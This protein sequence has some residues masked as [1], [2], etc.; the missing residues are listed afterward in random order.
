MSRNE[1]GFTLPETIIALAVMGL[2]LPVIF[3]IFYLVLSV[4]I[5]GGSS[6][7]ASLEAAQSVEVISR[8]GRSAIS[9]STPVPA[10]PLDYGTFYWLDY[11]VL[12]PIT[13]TVRYYYDPSNLSLARQET[14]GDSVTTRFIA[15]N[16]RNFGDVA[17]FPVGDS[18]SISVTSSI[19]S[20]VSATGVVTRGVVSQAQSRPEV[21]PSGFTFGPNQDSYVDQNKPTLN[22]GGD[23]DFR[24][25]SITLSP[26]AGN[27]RAFVQFDMSGIPANSLIRFAKLQLYMYEAP[28]A[29]RTYDAQRLTASWVETS[30]NWNNQPAVAASVSA[31]ATTGIVANSWVEW[32]V[33]SDVQ[34]IA[35]GTLTN[36]GWRIADHAESSPTDQQA[37]FRAREYTSVTFRPRL[38]V[39]WITTQ[40]TPTPTPSGVPQSGTFSATADAALDSGHPSLNDGAG[41]VMPLDTTMDG[42][43]RFDISSIPTVGSTITSAVL[44]M[45]V[46]AVGKA[47]DQKLYS[48]YRVLTDWLE[49]TVTWNNPGSVAG[50]NYASTATATIIITGT[51]SYTWDVTDDVIAY[52]NGSA[53]NRG[54]RISW[55]NNLTGNIESATLGTRENATAGNRPALQVDYIAPLPTATPTPTPTFTPTPTATP[56]PT[57]TPTVTPT[58]T[59]TPI[60]VTLYPAHDSYVDMNLS[61]TN[62]GGLTELHVRSTNTGNPDT[63]QRTFL[64]SS[65]AGIPPT[66]TVV[67]AT[68][69]LYMFGAP[70]ATRNYDAHRATATWAESTITWATQPAVAASASAT[71]ATGTTSN[72]W[73]EW[74]VTSDVQGFINGSLSNYGWRLKDQVES[75]ATDHLAQFYSKEQ[76]EVTQD[77]QLVVSY[78]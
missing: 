6:L 51:R 37:R 5:R 77:P 8:D 34:A 40:P 74:T 75:S 69:R 41:T 52:I 22:Y 15:R 19:T 50:V 56:T 1:R 9:F 67:S 28:S 72:V 70:T 27:Q 12:P 14:V 76:T 42:I 13:Y 66:A 71:T 25:R 68:L 78:R 29:S 35:N 53:T 64:Q 10:A 49:N 21:P 30:I 26:S 11:S 39:D 23:N 55:V 2:V 45:T 3:S 62:Y 24:V 46:T 32:D 7:E 36:Y 48:V 43:V 31:T 59:P 44:T 38:E 17:L 61:S 57:P 54:W 4:P 63:N 73:L 47:D 16:V 60:V 20:P 33:T 65:T 18:I 58:P